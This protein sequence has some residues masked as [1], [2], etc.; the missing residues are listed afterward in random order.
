APFLMAGAVLLWTAG[1]DIIYACQDFASDLET[2]VVSVPARIGIGPALWVSRLTHLGSLAF[3]V[4]LGFASPRLG[5]LY[6]VGVTLAA[7]LLIV[8]HGMVHADD[9]SKVGIAFFT[10]NGIISLLIGAL[11]I[12]DVCL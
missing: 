6:F 11:G 9:L 8:E 2:G 12:L 1:F 10:V 7:L 5:I 4:W 3:M